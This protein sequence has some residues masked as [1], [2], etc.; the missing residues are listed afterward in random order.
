MVALDRDIAQ[1][2]LQLQAAQDVAAARLHRQQLA[3][4]AGDMEVVGRRLVGHAAGGR[5]D[6]A[7]R[8]HGAAARVEP[9]HLPAPPQRDVDQPIL[10]LDQAARLGAR[11]KT[12]PRPQGPRAEVDQ[13]H[14][15]AIRIRGDRGLVITEDEQRP[16]AY[17]RRHRR[18]TARRGQ[19]RRLWTRHAA[20]RRGQKRSAAS[21]AAGAER[22]DCPQKADASR[23]P[24]DAEEAA[25]AALGSLA[26]SPVRTVTRCL[27]DHHVPLQSISDRQ[28]AGRQTDSPQRSA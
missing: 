11:G 3:A 9:H 24:K 12:H 22:R 17:R 18:R 4:G 21:A 28:S 6:R 15:V 5:T 19:R 10:I 1:V 26:R 8:H 2:A 25:D 23:C 14:R 20:R 27:L 16:T 13:P 7:L